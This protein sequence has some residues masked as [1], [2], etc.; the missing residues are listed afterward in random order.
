MAFSGLSALVIE[1]VTDEREVIRVSARTRDESVPCPVCGQPTRRVHGFHG[2]VVADVSVGGRRVVV[3]VRV[4]RLV[5][6]VLGCP[7]QTFREQVP[8][9]VERYQR[10]T[11]RLADQRDIPTLTDLGYE[12]TGDGFHHPVKKPAGRELAEAQQP[13]TSPSRHCG[14]SAGQPR[15][16]PYHPDRRRSPR[17][18][19]ARVTTAPPKRSRTAMIAYRERLSDATRTSA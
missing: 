1:G 10:H 19:P 2:R 5:C 6:P 16:Q 9:F 13:L 7:R 11:D 4:R 17:P 12:N 18:A 15:P 3:S 8:G 14:G